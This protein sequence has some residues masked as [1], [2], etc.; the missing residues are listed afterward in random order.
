MVGAARR[1][2]GLD[3]QGTTV[4][5]VLSGAQSLQLAAKPSVVVRWATFLSK[6][7]AVTAVWLASPSNKN[8]A[9]VPLPSFNSAF[10]T[11]DVTCWLQ[12]H[13][14]APRRC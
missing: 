13:P 9:K 12:V 10:S 8:S 11:G 1:S 2:E 14:L 3:S 5:L 7:R 4:F 6:G